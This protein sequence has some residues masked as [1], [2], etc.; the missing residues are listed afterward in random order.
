MTRNLTTFLYRAVRRRFVMARS[1][2][3]RITSAAC[4]CLSSSSSPDLPHFRAQFTPIDSTDSRTSQ[5]RCRSRT[6][7]HPS[8]SSWARVAASLP[9]PRSFSCFRTLS[10]SIWEVRRLSTRAC[11]S[12][13]WSARFSMLCSLASCE[14]SGMAP[15]F[16]STM[17]RP[18]WNSLRLALRPAL[19]TRTCSRNC[20]RSDLSWSSPRRAWRPPLR[21]DSF[22]TRTRETRSL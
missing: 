16:R 12:E 8:S 7:S 13:S 4:R 3:R 17:S 22:S 6:C 19:M 1:S 9:L 2:Q 11:F 20:A 18:C 14:K 15:L 5:A 21:G 10:S